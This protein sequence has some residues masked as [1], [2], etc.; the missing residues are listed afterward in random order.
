LSLVATPPAAGAV[1]FLG[2]FWLMSAVKDK[3]TRIWGQHIAIVS[4]VGCVIW[5]ALEQAATRVAT[6]YSCEIF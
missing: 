6:F 5:W 4:M 3:P 1:L 2:L